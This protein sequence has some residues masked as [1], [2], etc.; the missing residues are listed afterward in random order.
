METEPTM[1]PNTIDQGD[2]ATVLATFPATSIDCVVTSPPYWGL[3]DDG[4]AG[5]LGR[6]PTAD[7]YL[8]HLLAVMDE[9]A[10]VLAPAGTL[11]VTL[12]DTYRATSLVCLP[13]R[14]AAAMVERG[15]ALRNTIIWHKPRCRPEN[16]ADR[17]TVDFEYLF[18]FAHVHRYAFAQ[19]REAARD[20]GPRQRHDGMRRGDFA[21]TGATRGRSGRSARCH[22]TT[23]TR[24]ASRRRSSPRRSARGARRGASSSTPSWAAARRRSSPSASGGATRA[25][26]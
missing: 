7:A 20:W 5:Q 13:C 21:A 9:L 26:K 11:W 12:G 1:T 23:G 10:R 6:E 17:F 14:F 24:R 18:F 15:W 3:R 4:V 25:S 2:A 8:D 22:R 19:Q 16:V